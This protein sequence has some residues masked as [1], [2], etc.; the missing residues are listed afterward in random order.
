LEKQN[1]TAF[2]V[3]TKKGEPS[4]VKKKKPEKG[5]ANEQRGIHFPGLFAIHG[6]KKKK[7]KRQ[8]LIGAVRRRGGE[9]KGE[10]SKKETESDHE[11]NKG[12]K[13]GSKKK[14][15]TRS[16]NRQGWGLIAKKKVSADSGQGGEKFCKQKGKKRKRP[17]EL[18][19]KKRSGRRRS[20]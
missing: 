11:G 2:F 16:P 7:K 4:G 1:G 19:H 13:R 9:T 15:Q 8:D 17:R 20:W 18:D 10:M 14:L 3:S 5:P 6:R 12:K